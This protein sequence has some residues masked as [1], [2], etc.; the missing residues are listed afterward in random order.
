VKTQRDPIIKLMFRKLWRAILFAHTIFF[1]RRPQGKVPH[2]FYGGARSGNVGGPLVKVSRLQGYFPQ[3]SFRYNLIYALSNAP[4][5]SARALEHLRL[6]NI[7]IV[8][9]QNGVFYPGWYSGDSDRQN[10]MMAE[11]YHRADYVFWQSEFCR[12]SADRFLGAREGAGEVLFNAVDLD[13][14]S[15]LEKLSVRP[16]TFLLT[17]K[18]SVALNYRVKSTI[19]GLALARQAGTDVKLKISGWL[20]DPASIRLMAQKY[21][22]SD[23]VQITGAYSQAEA[24]SIYQ[25]ADAYIMTKYLDPCPNTVIEALACG[26]PVLYSSIVGV[27]EL[28]GKN[29]GIGLEVPENFERIHIPN[30]EAIADGMTRLIEKRQVMSEAARE[31]AINLFDI[32]LW[33]SRHRSVFE[34]LLLR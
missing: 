12:R 30:D 15:P 18:I 17:G 3:H 2:V 34:D 9:N 27:P 33:I 14:F 1:S 22:V 5:L 4:Y 32:H 25:A 24:P 23:Y 26:L 8:L 20:Q 31:R 10:A 21:G 16:F 29:A 6:K 19:S 11:M 28:V 7:P 13:Q